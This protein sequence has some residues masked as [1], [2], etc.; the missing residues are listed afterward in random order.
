MSRS[1]RCMLAYLGL[2][3]AR[4]VRITFDWRLL[5]MRPAG[6]YRGRDAE[7]VEECGEGVFPSPQGVESGEAA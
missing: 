5:T 6:A 2:I 4:D 1:S 3:L 7:S